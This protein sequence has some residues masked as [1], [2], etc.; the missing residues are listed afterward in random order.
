MKADA[1]I[2]GAPIPLKIP[3][4]QYLAASV[5]YL[6]PQWRR[7][8]LMAVLLLTGIA[9]Q[10]VSPLILR[11]FIDTATAGGDLRAL[12]IAALLF[13]GSALLQQ[14]L[15]VAATY[16]SENVAWTATN[17]LRRDLAAH[18][19]DL[20][21]S[22]HND[23]T[24]G[25]L[26]ERI[27]GDVT[28]LANFFSE[29]VIQIL[30]SMLLVV[31]V[32]ALLFRLDWRI[33]L[34]L[35]AFTII[36]LAVLVRLR[37]LATPH[38][39]VGRQATA[40]LSGFLEER[41]AGTE[42]IRSSRATD[43]VMRQFYTLMRDIMLAY[44]K[45]HIMGSV[46][47][48][49]ARVGFTVGLAIGLG[50]GAHLYLNGQISIGTVFLTGYYAGIL[51]F[52]LATITDQIDDL[53]QAAA[54]IARIAALRE[55]PV[56][57]ARAGRVVLPP[58]P[59][60]VAFEHVTFEYRAGNPVLEE[61]SFDVPAGEILGL[62]GRTG[63]GK[64]TISRLLFRLY[65]PQR[66]TIRLAGLDIR[67]LD[68]AALRRQIGLVTQ[69]VQLFHASVRDNLTFFDP[70]VADRKI[71]EA[72]ET[73]GLTTWYRTLP[74]GLETELRGSGGLSAG[75]AQVLAMTRM[76]L[77]DPDL[78]ILDEAS[79]RL[80]VA[81]ERLIEHA[82]DRLL[83]GRTAIIIAHRLRTVQRADSIM[84]LGERGVLEYGRR[85]DLEAD[86]NSHFARLLRGSL[87]L[88]AV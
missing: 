34:A 44:R 24:P 12:S 8:I 65:E 51:S 85:A 32:L 3:L 19:L 6:R 73:L 13:L 38:W 88:E 74:D 56:R 20:D 27:D 5:P 29:F 45:A 1:I 7:V 59:P 9:L 49:L 68:L 43:H 46:S 35:L 23:H 17:R 4:R 47:L 84:I 33:G 21:M 66:G 10:L 86:E 36:V 39:I 26:I 41:L 75:E 37:G 78:V 16:W 71:I 69:D 60:S 83:A 25:E 77:K 81:T 31:G 52:P 72:I 57:I 14:V 63:S 58:E 67:S 70:A 22:F 40:D 15:G 42:D 2:E 54:G 50:I 53:Q 18:C 80:D 28:L 64:T 87:E 79:S 62:L 82:I 61:V 48:G 55:T 11:Y 76:L 30:G